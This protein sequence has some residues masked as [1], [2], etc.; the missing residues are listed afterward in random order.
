MKQVGL[1]FKPGVKERGSYGCAQ[2]WIR[3]G[4]SVGWRN[5]FIWL[6]EW[7]P[8]SV[9]TR[10]DVE[11]PV[12][13]VNRHTDCSVVGTTTSSTS[14]TSTTSSTFH[15]LLFSREAQLSQR[16][17]ATR[18]ISWIHVSC[19]TAVRKIPV[20][21]ACINGVYLK[22]ITKLSSKALG[23]ERVRRITQFFYLPPTRLS[24]NGMSHPV[25]LL[26]SPHFGRYSVPVPQRLGG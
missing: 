16:A 7:S 17:R 25:M 20:E 5:S 22:S 9:L 23:M 26:P 1:A 12:Q 10:L 11:Q 24:T 18:C 8:I 2:W 19:W 14:D 6:V 21:K 13:A 4:R 3:R 15:F